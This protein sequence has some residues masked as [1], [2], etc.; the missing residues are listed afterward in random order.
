MDRKLA[1]REIS[2]HR[3][4]YKQS[5]SVSLSSVNFMQKY[6][7]R[8]SIFS[9]SQPAVSAAA[10][11]PFVRLSVRPSVFPMPY[12]STAVHFMAK[13][14]VERTGNLPA[15]LKKYSPGGCTIDMPPSNCHRRGHIVSPRDA[16]LR[17][18]SAKYYAALHASNP[19]CILKTHPSIC[20]L[21]F[22]SY[23]VL[24]VSLSLRNRR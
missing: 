23:L 16:L 22:F 4:C 6:T 21:K 12:T 24:Y 1:S 15:P 8:F 7:I 11:R 17:L 2:G 19:F 13:I 18:F 9:I 3:N 14:T 20:V 10:I 5:L